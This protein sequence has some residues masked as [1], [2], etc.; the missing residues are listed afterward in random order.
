MQANKVK[1]EK[2]KIEC[3]TPHWRSWKLSPYLHFLLVSPVFSNSSKLCGCGGA[4]QLEDNTDH[5]FCPLTLHND[6]CISQTYCHD[7]SLYCFHATALL[8]TLLIVKG[9][10]R[11]TVNFYIFC[12]NFFFSGCRDLFF[13]L[14]KKMLSETYLQLNSTETVKLNRHCSFVWV[15]LV[16]ILLVFVSFSFCINFY[17]SMQLQCPQWR[18]HN[19]PYFLK[20]FFLHIEIHL[21]HQSL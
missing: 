8:V 5:W 2:L 14:K 9:T 6:L 12:C 19:K 16:N 3:S 15:F 21:P 18:M 4:L 20:T 7:N 1:Q 13:F 17:Q 11:E 10:S